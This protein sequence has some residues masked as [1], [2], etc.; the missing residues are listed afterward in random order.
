MS[1]ALSLSHLHVELKGRVVVNDVSLT[2]ARGS[3]TAIVGRSG[4]GKSVLMKAAAGLLMR[5]SGDVLLWAPPLVFVHQDP[6]LIDDLD[7]LH[8]VMLPARGQQRKST[9]PWHWLAALSI[10]DV[11]HRLPC[12]LSP[13]QARRVA[14]AR[15]LMLKPGVLVVDEPT[16]GLD[17]DA[18]DN[19]DDALCCVVD[20]ERALI[21]I[22]HHP[23]TLS[24][25]RQLKDA[26]VVVIDD[27]R[28]RVVTTSMSS[29]V[30]A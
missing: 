24:R 28:A 12:E 16:T 15:A 10:D 22:T 8:N 2:F 3:V 25:L 11:A 13:S 23:R 4:A 21:V 30:L 7:V 27:G 19:V 17:P 6:A 20:A 29:E 5:S 26:S 14:L 9:D 18:S 1:A